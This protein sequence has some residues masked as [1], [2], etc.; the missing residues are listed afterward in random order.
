[1][2]SGPSLRCRTRGIREPTFENRA[3]KGRRRRVQVEMHSFRRRVDSGSRRPPDETLRGMSEDTSSTLQN[4][5]DLGGPRS[6]A[7]RTNEKRAS[8]SDFQ[9][10]STWIR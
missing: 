6:S 7:N 9:F 1:M 8:A 3:D 2:R 4:K 5:D 10:V